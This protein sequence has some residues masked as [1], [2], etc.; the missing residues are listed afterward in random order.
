MRRKI[1]AANWKMHKTIQETRQFLEELARHFPKTQAEIWIA[2]P[3]TALSAAAHFMHE[4]GL[5]IR[6][7]AQN[8]GNQPQGAFTGEVSAAMLK[9]AGA[10]FCI[11][12][13]SER[14]TLYHENDEMVHAKIRMALD[15]ALTPLLCVGES[16]R[17]REQERVEDVLRFQLGAALQ[18]RTADEVAHLCI[19]YEPIWAIGTGKT[20]T[21]ALAQEA[22]AICRAFLTHQ[23]GAEIAQRVPILYGG[24]VKPDNVASLFGG[25]DIDGALIGGASLDPKNFAQLITSVQA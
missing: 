20:A 16:W 14:R 10:S 7:G 19:A 17:E 11:V 15:F 21:P 2:P 1:L 4:K 13:H 25:P 23:W 8:V 12:G 22:H 3:V 18:D 24:S 9:E 6:L 5:K